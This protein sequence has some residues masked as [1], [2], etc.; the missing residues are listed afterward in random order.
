MMSEVHIK[1]LKGTMKVHAVVAAGDK[2]YTRKT[3]CFC[4]HCFSSDGQF[5]PSCDG[6]FEQALEG[7]AF[8]LD[9]EKVEPVNLV[10]ELQEGDY[11]IARYDNIIYMLYRQSPQRGC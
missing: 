3:S 11:I 4:E 6:W 8:K 10:L 9:S 7:D 2:L 1:P 5:S